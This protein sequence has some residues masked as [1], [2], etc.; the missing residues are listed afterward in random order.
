[1]R[2]GGGRYRFAN[3]PASASQV[4]VT[5]H[6]SH[7]SAVVLQ[8]RYESTTQHEHLS[9]IA[10]AVLLF[11]ISAR[12]AAADCSIAAGDWEEEVGAR[13]G[14]VSVSLGDAAAAAAAGDDDDDDG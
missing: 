1:M 14:D 4:H 5:R 10:A 3:A 8:P 7:V 13:D 9:L 6:T 12:A 2:R 11:L